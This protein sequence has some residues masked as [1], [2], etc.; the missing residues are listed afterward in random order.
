MEPHFIKVCYICSIGPQYLKDSEEN[1]E[2]SALPIVSKVLKLLKC[3]AGAGLQ[4]LFVPIFSSNQSETH[5]LAV[6]KFRCLI[7]YLEDWEVHKSKN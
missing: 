4:N 3:L 7:Y 6:S 2:P 5:N 1:L